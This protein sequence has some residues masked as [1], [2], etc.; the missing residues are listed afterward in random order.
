MDSIHAEFDQLLSQALDGDADWLSLLTAVD[1]HLQDHFTK[2]DLWMNETQFP[3][4]DCHIAEH[5]AVLR[6]S[7][8]VLALAREG[9]FVDARS[10]IEALADWFPGHAD[11][12]DSALAAWMCKRRYGG[13]PVVLH[14][15][16][17][18]RTG[19]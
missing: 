16:Q 5:A 9:N 19:G 13:K 10:L 15:E 17:L 1:S 7:S 8:E 12:M 4:R 11:F 2:E 6:S 14:R 18:A 3:A